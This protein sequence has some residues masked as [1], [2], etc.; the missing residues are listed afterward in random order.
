MEHLECCRLFFFEN[1]TAGEAPTISFYI[2]KIKEA[3]QG[4]QSYVEENFAIGH[5]KHV[6][7]AEKNPKKQIF[8]IRH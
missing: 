4:T 7:L 3:V 5:S 8:A 6:T 2:N 1:S